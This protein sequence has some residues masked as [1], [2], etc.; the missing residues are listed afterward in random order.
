MD[1]VIYFLALIPPALALLSILFRK[2]KL[3]GILHY[4]I[5]GLG[6]LLLAYYDKVIP[7]SIILIIFFIREYTHTNKGQKSL[8]FGRYRVHILGIFLSLSFG[9]VLL[10]WNSIKLKSNYV[11][12]GLSMNLSD[13]LLII[14]V[15][16]LINMSL[17]KGK[18]K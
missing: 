11:S 18:V 6:G 4:T 12:S 15:F 1:I 13:Y 7:L 16:I 14:L 3:S 9:A 17:L 2:K 8:W 10:I 5:C